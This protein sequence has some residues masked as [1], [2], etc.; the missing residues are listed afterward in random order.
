MARPDPREPHW[1]TRP[2]T[3]R[4]LWWIFGVVLALTVVAQFV[5]PLEGHFGADG[6]FAFNAWFGFLACAALILIAKVLGVLI[7]RPE[8]Y[9]QVREEGE[10]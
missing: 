9:Y 7:K 4:K 6:L 3:I 8:D 10:S 5:V 1:L 2:D